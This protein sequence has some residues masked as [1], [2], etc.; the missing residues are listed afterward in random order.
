[1]NKEAKYEKKALKSHQFRKKNSFL[2]KVDMNFPSY[3]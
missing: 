2:R 3:K 1:M